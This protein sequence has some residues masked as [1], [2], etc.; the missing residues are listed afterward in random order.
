MAGG[1]GEAEDAFGDDAAQGLFGAAADAGGGDP[2]LV[3]GPVVD[4]HGV[5][6]PHGVEEFIGAAGQA[7]GR[8]PHD[9]PFCT[10][11]VRHP[12]AEHLQHLGVDP[13]L[14]RHLADAGV[15]GHAPLPH[16]GQHALDGARHPG[17]AQA[18]VQALGRQGRHRHRPSVA[19]GAHPAGVGHPHP[20]EQHLVEGGAA[21]HLPHRADGDPG[22]AHVDKEGRAPLVL[23]DVPVGAGQED[24][25]VGVVGG[26]RPDLVAG[27]QPAVAV[28][29]GHRGGGHRG[30]VGAGV[31]LAEQLAPDLVGGQ[32]RRQVPAPLGLGAVGH[33]RRPDH[34]LAHQVDPRRD[35]RGGRLRSP[36]HPVRHR[37]TPPAMLHRP[38]QSSP[39]PVKQLPLPGPAPH[40][41]PGV[42]HVG[43]HQRRPPRLPVRPG[44]LRQPRPGLV[45][46]RRVL[47]RLVH[48]SGQ[49]GVAVRAAGVGPGDRPSA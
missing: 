38:P 42:A 27:D 32:D 31:G 47:S 23:G 43:E 29:R 20:V 46:E 13:H 28:L 4:E 34:G 12:F 45:P 1:L 9:R 49:Y 26:R 7:D 37:Q 11:G 24:A 2:E 15:V 5:G 19:N 30:Q 22:R 8:Q 39:A 3:E 25:P 35:P 16:L 44:V 17:R 21:R 40:H 33:E 14:G 36:D 10:R 48:H 6:A 41:V 18:Q